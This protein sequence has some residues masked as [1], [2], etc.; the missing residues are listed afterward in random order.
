M[1]PAL[2]LA[3]A[4]AL[5]LGGCTQLQLLNANK[6]TQDL[7]QKADAGDVESQYQMGLHF[8]AGADIQQNYAQGL[9]YF[10]KA[11][12]NGHTGAQYMLGMGYYLGRGTAQDYAEARQWLELAAAKHHREAMH[13]LGEIYL[14]GYGTRAE[15]AWGIHWIGQSAEMGY[16]EAQ[17]LLGTSYLTG[18]GNTKNRN[19]GLRWLS[20]AA[21]GGSLRAKELL[22]QIDQRPATSRFTAITRELSALNKRYRIRYAQTRLN[23]LGFTAGPADGVWGEQTEN[24]S[25]RFMKRSASLDELIE[26]LRLQPEKH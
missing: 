15:P 24:A 1:K 18:I 12:A 23:S 20:I 3:F 13:Y 8:T 11:A 2:A 26:T 21:N 22:K 10:R 4:T 5:T 6:P 14:N 7:A 9:S 16:S 25:L 17:Y 19:Q